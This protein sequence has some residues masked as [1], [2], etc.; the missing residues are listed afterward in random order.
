MLENPGMPLLHELSINDENVSTARRPYRYPYDPDR[1]LRQGPRRQPAAAGMCK[2]V[3]I[4]EAKGYCYGWHFCQAGDADLVVSSDDALFGHPAFPLRRLGSPAV[5]VGR[6]HGPAQVL[7][8]LFTGRPFTAQEMYE[9]GF[10]N[11][12]VPREKLGPKH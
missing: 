5:V 3:T 10:L 4:V 11:S 12:V 1:S 6:D 8:M 2:K 7:E 9:C